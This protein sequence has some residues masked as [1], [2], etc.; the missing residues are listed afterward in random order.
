MISCNSLSPSSVLGVSNF[1]V[2]DDLLFDFGG[3]SSN[4]VAR[5]RQK[6]KRCLARTGSGS[7]DEIWV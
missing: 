6:N 2:L 4:F 7:V 3:S 5:S 1:R